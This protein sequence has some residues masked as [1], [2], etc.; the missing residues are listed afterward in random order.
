MVIYRETNPPSRDEDCQEIC[1]IN[2]TRGSRGS[3][4]RQFLVVRVVILISVISNYM[5]SI[6]LGIKVFPPSRRGEV[7]W[8]KT[9]VGST[10]PNKSEIQLKQSD[11][12]ALRLG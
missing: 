6:E 8:C 12:C 5:R 3:E 9:E 1:H 7:G 2:S 4:Q 11:T 10:V